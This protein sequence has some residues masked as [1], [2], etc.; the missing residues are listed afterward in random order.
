LITGLLPFLPKDTNLGS[1]GILLSIIAFGFVIGRAIHGSAVIFDNFW[2]NDSHRDLFIGELEDGSL[3]PE[4][5][6]DR[7]YYLCCKTFQDLGLCDD[8]QDT[9][10]QDDNLE[11]IYL[12]VRSYLHMDSRGRSRTFQALFSFYRSM[13]LVALSLVSVYYA[14]ALINIL[15]LARSMVS[16]ETYVASL[17]IPI[18]IIMGGAI[19]AGTL[20]YRVFRDGKRRHQRHFVEYLIA[21]FVV[22]QE[23]QLGSYSQE[24]SE[25]NRDS[26]GL[27]ADK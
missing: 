2:D 20:A 3:L 14:Y 17:G 6:L 4:S 8:R 12:L 18:S 7:F 27:Q 11:Q 25:S 9:I 24:R 19:T 1:S 16:Y 10:D 21:D 23:S 13:W 26:D 22:L 5:T 15:G